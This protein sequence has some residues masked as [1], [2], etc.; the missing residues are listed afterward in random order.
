NRLAH[1]TESAR[2]QVFGQVVVTS[3]LAHGPITETLLSASSGACLVVMGRHLGSR[4]DVA[5]RCEVPV[6]VVPEGWL[7]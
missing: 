3:R 2:H 5:A 4:N 6:V 1:S 7:G